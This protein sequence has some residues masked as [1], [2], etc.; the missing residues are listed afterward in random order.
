MT[1]QKGMTNEKGLGMAKRK[2]GKSDNPK[3]PCCAIMAA[4]VPPYD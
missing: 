4:Q 1:N 2:S 3:E